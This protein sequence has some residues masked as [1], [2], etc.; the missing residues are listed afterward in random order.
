[1]KTLCSNCKRRTSA[2][3]ILENAVRLLPS[4]P[5]A[6]LL[7]NESSLRVSIGYN[8]F[9]NFIDLSEGHN[10]STVSNPFLHALSLTQ[11]GLE[12]KSFLIPQNRGFPR[13]SEGL[14]YPSVSY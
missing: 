5:S 11:G 10:S 9:S 8:N 6:Y 3:H 2:D 14:L 4:P 7:R 12:R 13:F 1:M